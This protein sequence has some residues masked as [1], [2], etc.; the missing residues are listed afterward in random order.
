MRGTADDVHDDVDT[1]ELLH[2]GVGYCGTALGSRDIR[3]HERLFRGEVGG[4]GPRR[5]EDR[6]AGFTQPRCDGA[7]DAFG[8]AGDKRTAASEF[9]GS[10][11][12][13]LPR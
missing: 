7:A 13:I 3:R 11:H 12:R 10:A 1:A 9:K 2:H 8:R 6:R 4:S 5:A